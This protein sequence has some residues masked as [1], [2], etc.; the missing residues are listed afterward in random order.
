MT[1]Y[2]YPGFL[3]GLRASGEYS[4]LT[5]RCEGKDL[6]VHKSVVCP[7]SQII[8]ED[9][10]EQS[11]A[12]EK[13]TIEIGFDLATCERMVEFLYTGDYEFPETVE[14][15]E[16]SHQHQ[17]KSTADANIDVGDSTKSLELL[18]SHLYV[19]AIADEYDIPDLCQLASKKIQQALESNWSA[20]AFIVLIKEAISMSIERETFYEMAAA[21]TVR[22]IEEL[23]QLDTFT[24][25][26]LPVEFTAQLLRK[27]S[28]RV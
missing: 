27:F 11:K 18:P 12:S 4:D 6:V 5:F 3:Y 13:I 7:Q 21:M 16:P 26:E 28:Q 23:G 19:Y 9:V 15:S 8:A 25:L 24:T 17:N 22:H 14:P 10:R 1:G 20:G 2:F